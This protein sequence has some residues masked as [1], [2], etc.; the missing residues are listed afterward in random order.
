MH[1]IV[2]IQKNLFQLMFITMGM[3]FFACPAWSKITV[4]VQPDNQKI[5]HQGCINLA[6]LN[7]WLR[8]PS[9]HDGRGE[10]RDDIVISFMPG[11][12]ELADSIEITDKVTGSGKKKITLLSAEPDT[13][14]LKG[15]RKL[16]MR[17]AQR[18]I[19]LQK[20]LPAGV[21]V[22]DASHWLLNKYDTMPESTFGL[23]YVPVLEL[24]ENS[25]PMS[26]ATRDLNGYSKTAD[27][28]KDQYSGKWSF[29]LQSQNDLDR[30]KNDNNVMAEGYFMH[31]WAD[32][33]LRVMVNPV[34]SA[35]IFT[36]TQPKYGIAKKRRVKI[37][38]AIADLKK[39]GQ[40]VIDIDSRK[41]YLI[42]KKIDDVD[43]VEASYLPSAIQLKNAR[44]VEIK[45]INIF[46]VRDKAVVMQNVANVSISSMRIMFSAGSGIAA[47]GSNIKL[48]NIEVSN[49]GSSGIA[50]NG[51]DRKTL[52]AG[53]NTIE[54]SRVMHVGRLKHSYT[55]AISL[56]GVGNTVKNSILSDGP[57]AAI[58]FHGNNH[59]ISNNIISD[60]VKDSD[61][62]GAIYTG[63]DWTARGT[64]I[65]NNKIV[66][67][68]R[69]QGVY[70]ANAIYLDDQAS[71][72][73]VKNN[74][75]TNARRGILIGGGRDN[76]VTGNVFQHCSEGIYVD[77]RG[78]SP[79][80]IKANI[81]L[82]KRLK[83]FNVNRPPYATHYP[84][85]AKI[86]Q[87]DYGKPMGN[88]LSGNIFANC[89]YIRIRKPAD[90]GVEVTNS[91]IVNQLLTHSDG[92]KINTESVQNANSSL[93]IDGMQR[94][95][96]E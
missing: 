87:A 66:N 3:L 31:D 95:V 28:K 5:K 89:G 44:N 38:N 88:K 14:L 23:P 10:L 35:F 73:L 61:D 15:T 30:Y 32:E 69:D 20:H 8:A 63:R 46:A 94:I 26:L 37:L 96:Y 39:P 68:G 76:I 65:E 17:A 6:M 64:T 59:L 70:G 29:S 11:V 41:I 57:H 13:V 78:T 34:T 16:Y 51:G 83:E 85:L 18:E 1:G 4:C 2:N 91:H 84:A 47:N 19:I 92:I 77:A 42:P 43:K 36:G 72:I 86:E 60:F 82:A 81:E 7:K 58:I 53:N 56:S 24:F 49:S 27:V 93:P 48:S 40:W 22:A 90:S 33:M 80:A 79:A 12:Y 74:I 21:F 45:N 75:I 62:A 67:I 54:L 71:G 52:S 50:I 25:E 9:M 55:P